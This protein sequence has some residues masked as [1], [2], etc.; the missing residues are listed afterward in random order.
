MKLFP[1]LINCVFLLLLSSFNAQA[2]APEENDFLSLNKESQD[3]I[4]IQTLRLINQEFQLEIASAASLVDLSPLFQQRSRYFSQFAQYEIAQLHV[5]QSQAVVKRLKSL[6]SNQAVSS[7]KLLAQQNQLAIY[8]AELKAAKY[9]LDSIESQFTAQWGAVL[10][11]WLLN[12]DNKKSQPFRPFQQKIYR[13]YLPVSHGKAPQS[14]FLH[15][16][17]LREQAERASLI[18][19]APEYGLSAQAGHAYFYQI[20][21]SNLLGA[22]VN[23]W[24]PVNNQAQQGIIIPQAAL[25]WHLGQ[26]FVYLQSEED[27]FK[28]VKINQKIRLDSEHYFIP[29]G[30]QENDLLVISG[31]QVLLSEE[32]RGQI[33]AEDDDDDD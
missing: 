30:L 32:F 27:E 9:Q 3:L 5:K 28:R 17:N 23:A 33:P 19:A 18:S 22:R 11:Q 20:K 14:I 21:N 1:P 10:T 25:I 8:L 16:A 24:L 31:A 29:H 2:E 12:K 4:G 6:A 15:S 26:S 13:L 7:R